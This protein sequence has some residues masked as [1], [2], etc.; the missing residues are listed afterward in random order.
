MIGIASVGENEMGNS[1]QDQLL[2]AGL[3][4]KK[5]V[6]KA[7]HQ[8]RV[9][10]QKSKK[11]QKV[12]ID[13]TAPET[14]QAREERLVQEARNRE[15]NRQRNQEMLA[16]ERAAQVKQLIETNGVKLEE[17]GEPYYFAHGTR[18]KKVYASETQ[19]KQLSQGQ[20]AI[21]QV[22]ERYGAI[23]GNVAQQVEE[24][25]PEALIVFHKS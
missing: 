20:L 11:Q 16:R 2:K 12:S 7:K 3:V 24:R 15:L 19:I 5:Q 22:N 21:V 13:Q 25:D 18:V 10:R 17:N 23:P 4:N 6:K 9:T 8:N 1:F 14:N